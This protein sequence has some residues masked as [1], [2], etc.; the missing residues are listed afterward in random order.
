MQLH[1]KPALRDV[2]CLHV[3]AVDACGAICDGEAEPSPA[4]VPVSGIL[5]TVERLED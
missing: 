3:P 5:G 4:T 2:S 1:D